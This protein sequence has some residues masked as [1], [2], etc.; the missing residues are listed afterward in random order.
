MPWNG[1]DEEDAGAGVD[2]DG[3]VGVT[4]D[5]EEV[6][7]RIFFAKPKSPPRLEGAG[8]GTGVGGGGGTNVFLLRPCLAA[9]SC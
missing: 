8:V 4:E 1:D 9:L 2:D 3:A 7:E 5:E 6:E